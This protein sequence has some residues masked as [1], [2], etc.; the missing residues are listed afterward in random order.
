MKNEN[1]KK[2]YAQVLDK[3]SFAKMVA[4]EF[5]RSESSIKTNWL[6]TGSVPDYAEKRLHELLI[7]TLKA[8]I[9]KTKK[10]IG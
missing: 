2:L 5:N 8:Q 7:N 9:N 3:N 10:L 6:S 1:I 4:K